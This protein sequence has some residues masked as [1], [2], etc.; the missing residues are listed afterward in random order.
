MKIEQALKSGLPSLFLYLE[1]QLSENGVDESPIFQPVSRTQNT[2]PAT[3][4]DKFSNGFD[5]NF[6]S[7]A[8]RKLWMVKDDFGNIKGHI[9]LRHHGDE[10]SMHRVLPGIIM[11]AYCAKKAL[12]Q[13]SWKPL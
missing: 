7:V 12:V 6:D 2:L 1:N 11:T 3:A 8:W 10:N 5:I 13:S 4:K 9:D